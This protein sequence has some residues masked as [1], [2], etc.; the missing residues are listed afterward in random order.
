M[1]LLT[2]LSALA[3][4]ITQAYTARGERK[5]AIQKQRLSLIGDAESNNHN[6]E[7]AALE[8]EGYELPLIR[9]LAYIEISLC[10]YMAVYDPEAAKA[11]WI[12]LAEMPEY[13]MGMKLTV[14]AWAFAS[15][16]IKSAAA[17]LVTGTT[18]NTGKT[19][20]TG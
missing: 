2:V 9:L 12:A 17:G 6:W 15:T 16:P 11:I 13:I 14:F 8:G 20:N 18:G 7:I 19:G 10:T 4:P 1:S 5:A 3:S